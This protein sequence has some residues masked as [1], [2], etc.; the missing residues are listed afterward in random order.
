MLTRRDSWLVAR[1]S[2][3]TILLALALMLFQCAGDGPR[4]I[5]ATVH[6]GGPK[7]VWDLFKKPLPEIPVPNNIATR[8]DPSSPTGRRVTL[9]LLAPTQIERRVRRQAAELTGFSILGPIYV[10]FD[11]PLDLAPF[12][13]AHWP[14]NRDF[15]DD[16]VYLVNVD[17]KSSSFGQPVPLDVGQGNFPNV[18][19]SDRGAGGG[20]APFGLFENDP[21]RTSNNLFFETVD[22]DVNCNGSLDA[23]EDTDFDGVLDKPNMIRDSVIPQCSPT[24]RPAAPVDQ[25]FKEGCTVVS[26]ESESGACVPKCR[27]EECLMTFYE[28]ETNTLIVR[29][30]IPLEQETTYAVVLTTGITGEDSKPIESPFPFVNAATQ[31]DDLQPLADFIRDGKLPG[32]AMSDVA[33]AWTFTTQAVTREMEA[34]RKGMYGKGPFAWIQDQY[35]P[36]IH[37]ERIYADSAGRENPY[38]LPAAELDNLVENYGKELVGQLIG[39]GAPFVEEVRKSLKYTDYLVAGFVDT[40]YFLTD[41]DGIG[42]PSPDPNVNPLYPADNDESFDIDLRTGR[43][44]VGHNLITFVCAVPK[45]RPG[46]TGPIPLGLHSH[47]YTLHRIEGIGFAGVMNRFGI[48]YCGVDSVAHGLFKPSKDEE[49]LVRNVIPK[50]WL[51]LLDG[52]FFK[53][54]ARDLNNDG[55]ADSG[56]DF[57]GVDLFHTRDTVR[58]TGVDFFQLIRMFRSWDGKAMMD[59]DGDGTKETLAGDFNRDGVVD[60]G[61]PLADGAKY[62]MD[63][64]SNGGI[65]TAYTLGLEP[66][67]VA[68]IASS[69]AAGLTDVAARTTQDGVVEAVYLPLF[70]PIISGTPDPADP[71]TIEVKFV[72]TDVNRRVQPVFLRT[73]KIKAGQ[74][75]ELHNLRNGEWDRAVVSG[76]GRFRLAAAADALD[77]TEKRHL[78][79]DLG[80]GKPPDTVPDLNDDEPLL[81]GDPLEIRLCRTS[82]A[83]ETWNDSEPCADFEP[84]NMTTN[85]FLFQGA[86]YMA[87]SRIAAITEG[88]G[89]KRNSPRIRRFSAISQVILD[90]GDPGGSAPHYFKDPLDFSYDREVTD[91]IQRI[92]VVATDGDTAVPVNTGIHI[93][94]SAGIIDI[95]YPTPRRTFAYSGKADR[96]ENDL[97]VEH[98]AAEGVERLRRFAGPPWNDARKILF[99]LDDLDEGADRWDAQETGRKDADLDAPDLRTEGLAPLRVKVNVGDVQPGA[100]GVSGF[101]LP[102]LSDHGQH[103]FLP[104]DPNKDFNLDNYIVQQMA[105]FVSTDGRELLD[106]SCLES[107]TCAFHDENP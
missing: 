69:G 48:A 17:P 94:R 22:E 33:F 19:D 8:I 104:S 6:T 62:Y 96:V 100:S 11:R 45:R 57:W 40:P 26:Y 49:A 24:G 107:N 80:K 83:D 89:M 68:G 5:T 73:D 77:A 34:I 29:P 90:S 56:G 32:M 9:S 50:D 13:L 65:M 92:L 53:G 39:T 71:S 61:G 76:G 67:F 105:R 60:F 35:P 70:G 55:I 51:P 101:R 106:D 88:L 1:G 31:T 20:E 12:V 58:Q 25:I 99:D 91:P 84:I 36:D 78:L 37:V 75:I 3:G 30:L 79:G 72:L 23:G 46:Q 15:S 21:H 66:A 59:M 7:V 74:R 18:I 47:G 16:L 102:Y 14:P 95:G 43:A 103:C 93:A 87:R 2:W 52:V 41:K 44:T 38:L 10:Q 98:F 81:F 82:D 63:G 85:T 86:R 27:P 4:G 28:R 97:I 64:C 54:R 42:E